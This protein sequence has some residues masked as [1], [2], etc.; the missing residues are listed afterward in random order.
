[1]SLLPPGHS[2]TVRVPATSANLGPG[3]DSLGLALGLVDEVTATVVDEPGV[4]VEVVG[5]GAGEVP[6]G[7]DHLVARVLM[8]GLS[9]ASCPPPP[10]LLLRCV[11][12]VPHGRGLGSS[13]AAVIAGALL[14]RALA[15]P[16]GDFAEGLDGEGLDVGE[17][18]KGLDDD[19]VLDLATDVEGHPDN[20]AAALLGGAT[21]AWRGADGPRAVRI[22]VHPDLVPLVLLPLGR[23]AT[24]HARSVLPASVTHEDATANVARAALLVHALG[25]EPGL[26]L[27]ATHDRLHQRQ[28]RQ[29]MPATVDLVDRLR[30]E[31]VAAVV[32]G[33]GPAVLVL[34]TVLRRST[35]LHI[36]RAHAAVGVQTVA[37]S[38]DAWQ[39]LE[40]GIYPLGAMVR[41]AAVAN[42]AGG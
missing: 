26:L 12:A 20:A 15:A 32:S 18:V 34:S 5:E 33:A 2:A 38:S 8:A 16:A 11:N 40:P 10:G 1:M 7:P 13:A 22:A 36:V 29:A 35:D 23:L 42:R 27:E 19:A 37:H 25:R 3:F 6:C 21:V 9:R 14:A 24:H 28:R 4:R 30:H 39:L 31:G 41:L 17:D